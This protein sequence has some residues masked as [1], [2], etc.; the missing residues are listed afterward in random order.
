MQQRKVAAGSESQ[1]P[2]YLMSLLEKEFNVALSK[3]DLVRA[4]A[5]FNQMDTGIQTKHRASLKDLEHQADPRLK[6]WEKAYQAALQGGRA[7]LEALERNLVEDLPE[8]QGVP[9]KIQKVITSVPP[10]SLSQTKMDWPRKRTE[11]EKIQVQ[12]ESKIAMLAQRREALI[13]E[14]QTLWPL[15]MRASLLSQGQPATVPSPAD[16]LP[17]NRR[18]PLLQELSATCR[19]LLSLSPQ[20][21]GKADWSLWQR[22]IEEE[23]ASLQSTGTRNNVPAPPPKGRLL[24]W[25][26]II[27]G[28]VA[29]VVAVVV[30][31]AAVSLMINR[32]SAPAPISQTSGGQPIL[33][34]TTILPSASSV[35]GATGPAPIVQPSLTPI[36]LPT[37]TPQPSPAPPKPT[38]APT[39]SPQQGKPAIA[40]PPQGMPLPAFPW[41]IVITSTVRNTVSLELR[42]DDPPVT[43][44]TVNF[45][46]RPI[47]Y[48]GYLSLT[49]PITMEAEKTGFAAYIPLR[50]A[51]DFDSLPSG[52]Y[53]L[54][55]YDITN[56]PP[57]NKVGTTLF[58]ITVPQ[59]I[60]ATVKSIDIISKTLHTPSFSLKG[61]EASLKVGVPVNVLGRIEYVDET[62]KLHKL[63][64]K[65]GAVSPSIDNRWCLYDTTEG[66]AKNKRGWILCEFLNLSG[67]LDKIPRLAPPIPSK[68]YGPGS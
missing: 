49:E 37:V 29:A 33:S 66:G 12:L 63:N 46:G 44:L 26:F 43:P 61:D 54:N 11:L 7:A 1:A 60:S 59:D 62:G 52:V 57:G 64:S 3:Q 14:I 55:L 27:G 10:E 56:G 5:I 19:E 50:E 42:S 4:Q 9:E 48:T 67:Q 65:A 28:L 8:V 25:V 18:V 22:S 17:E 39:V 21:S 32:L 15:V 45:D 20:N 24:K 51:N 35:A 30:I 13:A 6:D 31:A 53:Y 23:L 47:S 68:L 2:G 38:E 16:T 34:P 36:T 40:F 41:Y 58:V